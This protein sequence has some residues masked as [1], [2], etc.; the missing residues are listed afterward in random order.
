MATITYT[1][2]RINEET[3]P[4]CRK[5]RDVSYEEIVDIEVAEAR[6]EDLTLAFTLSERL[7]RRSGRHIY[8]H[9]GLLYRPLTI[10]RLESGKPDTG[11]DDQVVQFGDGDFPEEVTDHWPPKRAEDTE[12]FREH[13][14]DKYSGHLIVGDDV[15]VRCPEPCFYVSE[16]SFGSSV[17]VHATDRI[18]AHC[19]PH[20]IFAADEL[21]EAIAAALEMCPRSTRM[22]VYPHDDLTCHDPESVKIVT[23][24]PEPAGTDDLRQKYE[25][26]VR[27][28]ER[29]HTPEGEAL[30]FDE[31]CQARSSLLESGSP[32]LT[33]TM[34]P[35]ENRPAII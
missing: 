11:Q 35:Y 20:M 1:G 10:S 30:A 8:A 16:S 29:A 21:D 9:E 5:P 13:V 24:P 2:T 4:R 14:Q 19:R 26:A 27:S 28:L 17:F 18:P 31:L 3:P 22:Q 25:V 15:Y 32:I 33:P 23:I 34:R 12:G 6:P 7:A